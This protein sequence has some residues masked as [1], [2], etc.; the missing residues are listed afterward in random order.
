MID[1]DSQEAFSALFAP[2]PAP[3]PELPAP[4]LVQFS[5]QGR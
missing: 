2:E 4:A 1:A 5:S 3:V